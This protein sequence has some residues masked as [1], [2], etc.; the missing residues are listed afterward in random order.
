MNFAFSKHSL[1]Q[2]ALRQISKEEV[3]SILK[4]SQQIIHETENS[5]YQ[6]EILKEGKK[7]LV[8]IFVNDKKSP[9]LVI[10]VY[11]TSKINKYK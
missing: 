2:M 4:S 7:Y 3:E 11:K 1:E 5:I 10:T 8:R 6:S 9:P